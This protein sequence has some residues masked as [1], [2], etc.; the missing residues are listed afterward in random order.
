[1]WCFAHTGASYQKK[2]LCR[3]WLFSIVFGILKWISILFHW[4]NAFFINLCWFFYFKSHDNLNVGGFSFLGN[5]VVEDVSKFPNRNLF[6]VPA[7]FK[8]KSRFNGVVKDVSRFPNQNLFSVPALSR[9]FKVWKCNH[10][11][12]IYFKP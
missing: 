4:E 3:Q 7:E 9:G 1:M 12:S 11:T 10:L 2:V 5:G 6:S 8:I